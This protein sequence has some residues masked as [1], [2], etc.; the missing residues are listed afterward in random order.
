[1]G[2]PF[3]AWVMLPPCVARTRRSALGSF[4]DG[5]S[6]CQRARGLFDEAR[7]RG[8]PFDEL[9]SAAERFAE[10]DRSDAYF[11][12]VHDVHDALAVDGG[13]GRA[14]DDELGRLL[15]G[16]FVDFLAQEAHARGHLR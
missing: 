1:M 6:V 4:F 3:V 15:D 11:S 16:L 12:A 9:E 13:E 5:L 8:R 7:A 2:V 10:R 14:R